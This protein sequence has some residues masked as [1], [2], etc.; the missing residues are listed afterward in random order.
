MMVALYSAAVV[1][2]VERLVAEAQEVVRHLVEQDSPAGARLEEL[3]RAELDTVRYR[4]R[5][6]TTPHA[7]ST[8]SA[9]GHRYHRHVHTLSIL[10]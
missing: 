2:A 7:G 6:R 1:L 5:H 4:A 3:H 8:D 10:A 9:Q